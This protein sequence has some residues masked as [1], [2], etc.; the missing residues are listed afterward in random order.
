MDTITGYVCTACGHATDDPA[1][2]LYECGNCGEQFNSDS[3]H[4]GRHMCPNC[5]KFGAKIADHSCP[6][7]NGGE[8]EEAQIAECNTCGEFFQPEDGCQRCDAPAPKPVIV[9]SRP[10]V[11][12]GE[13]VEGLAIG[14]PFHRECVA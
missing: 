6:E 7:C 2:S 1:G 9:H 4:N 8:A 11:E 14:T 5:Y 10:C 13:P 12:C 3:S